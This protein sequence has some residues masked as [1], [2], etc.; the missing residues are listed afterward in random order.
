MP[1]LTLTFG[2]RELQ[3]CPVGT[4]PVT[5]GRLPDNMVV[6]DNP[7]VSGRHARVFREGDDYIVEDLKST[8][9]TFVS[10]KPIVRRT[11]RDRD[12]VLVGKHSLVFSLAG[13]EHADVAE[14]VPYVPDVG[15]TM[16]LDTFRQ[17]TLLANIDSPK[18]TS[19]IGPLLV[20]QVRVVSGKTAHSEYTLTGITSIIG[21][22]DTA[23]I[24]LQ[25]WF[26]PKI[27]AALARKGEG[28]TVTSMG[29][30]TAVNGQVIAGRKDLR[31]GDLIEVAGLTLE[32]H[33]KPAHH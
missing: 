31:D 2:D 1:T 10:E 9:G 4:H 23:Q 5:I 19:P 3:S 16:M 20:G 6:I 13:G 30:K 22:A 14:P 26:K 33:L 15:G 29:A 27:A 7:A 32:F 28:Y 12:V 25:G 11:L 18:T 8:N 17:K 21:K 24:R